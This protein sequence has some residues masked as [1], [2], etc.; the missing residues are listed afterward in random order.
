MSSVTVSVVSHGHGAEV[1]ALLEGLASRCALLVR[2]VILTL[3]VPEASV[4]T[5]LAGRAWPFELTMLRNAAP[6]GYGAN[7][8]AAFRVCG[9][10]YFCVLNPD[11]VAGEDPFPALLQAC[12]ASGGAL[13]YPRQLARDG[14][15]QD[16]A[17]LVPTLPDLL[18]RH[19]LRTPFVPPARPDFVTGACMFFEARV[20][21]AIGGFDE[22]Y[23]MY[24]EDV[25]ICL[26]LQL[27]GH[28]L[29]PAACDVVHEAHR[30]SRSSLRPMIWHI[31]SLL[32]LWTSKAF[33]D[34]RRKFKT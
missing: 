4:E 29:A 8:N 23:F 32:R 34:Y 20:Y 5:A 25:D 22:R 6:K 3:N 26:R 16:Y 9:Q 19:L 18:R 11:V 30:A 10:P 21:G 7:H 12:V 17:R 13:A 27:A 31:S 14:T 33:H 15:P 24:C 28:V 2:Q 1:L